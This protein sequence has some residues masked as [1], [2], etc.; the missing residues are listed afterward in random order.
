MMAA[1][2]LQMPPAAAATTATAEV[3]ISNNTEKKM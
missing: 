2:P 3:A 1:A